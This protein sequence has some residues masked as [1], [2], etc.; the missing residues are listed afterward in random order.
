MFKFLFRH[1]NANLKHGCCV[2]MEENLGETD[3]A[4]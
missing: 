1:K 3:M 4:I 2:A